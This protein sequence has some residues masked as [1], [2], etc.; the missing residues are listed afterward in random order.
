MLLFFTIEIFLQ[1][2]IIINK[3]CR[4]ESKNKLTFWFLFVIIEPLDRDDDGIASQQ[5]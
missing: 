2:I 1:M 4:Y 5:G 3:L